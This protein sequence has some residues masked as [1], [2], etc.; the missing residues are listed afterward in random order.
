ML[1]GRLQAAHRLK[2]ATHSC[3]NG[4]QTQQHRDNDKQPWNAINYP[5]LCECCLSDTAAAA[6]TLA[7][8]DE[9]LDLMEKTMDR[10]S[11]FTTFASFSA[12][13]SFFLEK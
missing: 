8:E 13:F 7:N 10:C 1:S 4:K 5:N 12:S 9:S 3:K 6:A 11:L 2:P